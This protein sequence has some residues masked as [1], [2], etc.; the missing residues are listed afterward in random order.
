MLS[1]SSLSFPPFISVQNMSNMPCSSKGKAHHSRHWSQVPCTAYHGPLKHICYLSS[2][3]LYKRCIEETPVSYLSVSMITPHTGLSL[4]VDSPLYTRPPSHMH[5]PDGVLWNGWQ[6]G[7]YRLFFR[8]QVQA[9]WILWQG[10][11]PL[12]DNGPLAKKG[13]SSG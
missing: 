13:D 3:I 5:Q 2:C 4:P 9:S 7:H 8:L 11:P 1:L 6:R 12:L 10:Y